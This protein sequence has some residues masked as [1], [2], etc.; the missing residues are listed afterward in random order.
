MF[1]LTDGGYWEIE[2][3]E[4]QLGKWRIRRAPKGAVP[5]WRD[6]DSAP[7]S[8]S[9]PWWVFKP[10][11]TTPVAISSCWA[12]AMRHVEDAVLTELVQANLAATTMLHHQPRRDQ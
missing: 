2:F 6:P 4:T 12:A 7:E 9:R 10:G 3:S 5:P 8:D 1:R 11:A